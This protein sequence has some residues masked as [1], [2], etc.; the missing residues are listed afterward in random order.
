MRQPKPAVW[1]PAVRTGSGADVF[2]ERLAAALVRRGLRAEIAWLSHKAEYAPWTVPTLEPPPWA[3]VVH[4]NSWL[5]HRFVPRGLPLVVTVHGCVHDPALRPYKSPLQSLYHWAWIRRCERILLRRADA[6]TAVSRYT[7]DRVNSVFGV[8][9]IL[10][11]HNWIDTQTFRPDDRAAPNSPFRLLFVGNMSRRKGVDLLPEI[12]RRLGDGFELRYT[13]KGA[14]VGGAAGMPPNMFALGRLQGADTLAR[15]YRDSD[16][17]L[18]P[19]R[20]EGLVLVA[21]E[22]QACGRPVVSTNCSSMPEVVLPEVT[23]ILCPV[24]DVDAFVRAAR[25]LREEPAAWRRMCIAA[26][27]RAETQFG[28]E[29]AVNSY[30]KLYV[31]LLAQGGVR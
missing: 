17:L 16:A 19:T 3:N 2:T 21:I 24:D 10:P 20:L 25:R 14:D 11:I 30:I 29:E 8:R 5:H 6:V 12:M 4:A 7:A 13:G 15:V 31:R 26:R 23:G 27:E 1:F 9:G 18:L 22:A 28:E